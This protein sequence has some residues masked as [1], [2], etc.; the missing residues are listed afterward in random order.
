MWVIGDFRAEMLTALSVLGVDAAAVRAWDGPRSSYSAELLAEERP[1]WLLINQPRAMVDASRSGDR[2]SA[3]R[4]R[5][6]IASLLDAQVESGGQFV[7]YGNPCWPTWDAQKA[8][9]LK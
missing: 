6:R 3:A 8:P 7:M 5:R 4:L 9:E 1:A 2:D